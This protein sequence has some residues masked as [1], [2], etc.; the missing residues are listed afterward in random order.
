MKGLMKNSRRCEI[1]TDRHWTTRGLEQS[2]ESREDSSG[3]AAELE[4]HL[5]MRESLKRLLRR[6]L[7]APLLFGADVILGGGDVMSCPLWCCCCCW[8][9]PMRSRLMRDTKCAK[10]HELRGG[11]VEPSRKRYCTCV[12][13]HSSPRASISSSSNQYSIVQ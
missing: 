13:C 10:W 5:F 2:Q 3:A 12:I 7:Q 6:Q 4:L 11:P 9:E 8:Q 1:C